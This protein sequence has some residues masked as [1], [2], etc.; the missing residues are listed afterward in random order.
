MSSA[1]KLWKRRVVYNMKKWF[2]LHTSYMY[3]F[4]QSIRFDCLKS[5]HPCSPFG[6]LC[7]VCL[8]LHMQVFRCLAY[9]CFSFH[10]LVV[11]LARRR[12]GQYN[13]VIEGDPWVTRLTYFIKLPLVLCSKCQGVWE[14]IS[15]ALFNILIALL[16][17][18]IYIYKL[19]VHGYLFI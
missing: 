3:F 14:E 12:D 1:C 18:S 13:Y 2:T 16:W 6:S 10:L 7:L 9:N 15:F 4:F 8:W 19:K 5:W 11:S 17:R